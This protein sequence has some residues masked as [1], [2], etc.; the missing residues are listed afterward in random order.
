M[1]EL[2]ERFS[3]GTFLWSWVKFSTPCVLE[4]LKL[5]HLYVDSFTLISDIT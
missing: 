2:M 4:L 1:I 3:E 5:F